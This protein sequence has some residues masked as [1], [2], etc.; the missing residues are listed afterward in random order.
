MISVE[1]G[2]LEKFS[3]DDVLQCFFRDV[4]LT[5]SNIK[6]KSFTL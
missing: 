4:D 6:V 3:H 1:S 2:S 5:Y